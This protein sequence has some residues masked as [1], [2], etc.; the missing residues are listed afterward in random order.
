MLSLVILIPGITKKE[1]VNW[2]GLFWIYYNY[3][4]SSVDDYLLST[5]YIYTLARIDNPTS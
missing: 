1:L 2:A 5:F 4:V 3:I